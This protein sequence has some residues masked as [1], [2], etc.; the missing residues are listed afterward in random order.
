M[1]LK[2]LDSVLQGSLRDSVFGCI[3]GAFAGDSCGSFGEFSL[4]LLT[5]DEMKQC[6]AMEGGGPFK[7]NGGQITDDSEMAMCLL[8]AIYDSIEKSPSS[9]KVDERLIAKY[10]AK[11]VKT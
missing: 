10:Y 4:E 3:L 7:L 6:M 9:P 8:H 5:R 2:V 11:W 1:N